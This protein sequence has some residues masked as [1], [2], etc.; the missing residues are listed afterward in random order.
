MIF[1]EKTIDSEIIYSGSILNLRKDRV[2]VRTGESSRE[3]IEHNGG[4][5]ICAIT[6]DEK[7]IMVK[8]FRKAVEQ[9]MLE[10]PAGK[11]DGNEKAVEV[12]RRELKEETGYTADEF[13][14]LTT[15]FP[16]P[17]YSQ[18]ALDIFLA[19]G[20]VPGETDFDDNEAIDIYE[21]QLDDLVDMV[22]RGEIKDGKTQVAILMVKEYLRRENNA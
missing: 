1:E 13:I 11:R 7:I 22:M 18:E 16:T 4:A 3:I 8:Q 10:V 20:L 12:A 5:V 6:D 17:G 21:Y 9:V 2:T 14:H 19:R 15:M